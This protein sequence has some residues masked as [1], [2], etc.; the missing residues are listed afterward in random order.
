MAPVYVY[1]VVLEYPTSTEASTINQLV[2][3]SGGNPDE[4]VEMVRDACLHKYKSNLYTKI[5]IIIFL[6]TCIY[7]NWK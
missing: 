1:E 2:V 6:G 7:I 4:H 5:K 3:V